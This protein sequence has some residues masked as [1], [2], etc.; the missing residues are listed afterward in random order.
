MLTLGEDLGVSSL[1][2]IPLASRNLIVAVGAITW[3]S[4]VTGLAPTTFVDLLMFMLI[5]ISEGKKD[6]GKTLLASSPPF[7]TLNGWFLEILT[8]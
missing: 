1:F 3:Q 7:R 2:G 5:R 4:G 8:K 6:F